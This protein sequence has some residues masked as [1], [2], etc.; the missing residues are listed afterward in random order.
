[1]IHNHRDGHEGDTAL[2]MHQAAHQF[3]KGNF[4]N[5]IDLLDQVLAK[6]SLHTAARFYRGV[7]LMETGRQQE[8][9][10]DLGIVY[11][12][13]SAYRYDA[14]FYTALSYLRERDKQQCLE[15]LLK[16]PQNASI[17]WKAKQLK[18]ELTN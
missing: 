13:T 7:S 4:G 11:A 10:K 12:G 8:A 6:D 9:R 1:M 18:E 15:W 16:I 5:T 2:L 3:N 14:A 17:S